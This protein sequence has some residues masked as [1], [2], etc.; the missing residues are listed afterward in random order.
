M[1]KLIELKEQEVAVKAKLDPAQ[2][3]LLSKI[4]RKRKSSASNVQEPTKSTRIRR[5]KTS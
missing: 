2:K 5:R 3:E 1:Q 4:A